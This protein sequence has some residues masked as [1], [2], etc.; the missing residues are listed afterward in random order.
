VERQKKSI[1]FKFHVNYNS[2]YLS[3]TTVK[4]KLQTKKVRFLFR[5]TL[6]G[7]AEEGLEIAKPL[8]LGHERAGVPDDSAEPLGLEVG[9]VER[10]GAGDG[11][12]SA[13]R[14][15]GIRS[16]GRRQQRQAELLRCGPNA[17]N[18]IS[19]TREAKSGEEAEEK[20]K[21]QQRRRTQV[22]DD[23]SAVGAPA[24]GSAEVGLAVGQARGGEDG[25]GAVLDE[26][27]GV[28]QRV[29]EVEQ[30][31]VLPLRRR[32]L[33][34]RGGKSRRHHDCRETRDAPSPHRH[35]APSV[36]GSPTK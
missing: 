24:G 29:T 1:K 21:Q 36:L 11:K 25:R 27:A 6:G 26:V 23:E 31:A 9:R 33:P 12:V 28:G 15:A 32:L 4:A 2:L 8:D 35:R 7:V 14:E 18:L 16:L 17:R 34:F 3:I 22:V 20:L 30:R 19:G 13:V 5:P 10:R